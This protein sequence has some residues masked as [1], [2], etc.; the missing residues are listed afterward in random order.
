MRLHVVCIQARY[1]KYI[2]DSALWHQGDGL[3]CSNS[4]QFVLCGLNIGFMCYLNICQTLLGG[5]FMCYLNIC[6]TLLGGCFMCYLKTLLFG[7]CFRYV[8]Q[9]LKHLPDI[10]RWVFYVTQ[11]KQVLG[12]CFS[13]S[14]KQVL[15]GC[16][17]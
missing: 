1:V 3:V 4:I 17:M 2:P 8:T 11:Y 14:V 7:G 15:G 16:F 13:N 10:V 9:L 12:G 6:Q 5:C